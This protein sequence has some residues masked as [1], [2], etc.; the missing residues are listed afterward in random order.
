[1]K[2]IAELAQKELVK[3][4]LWNLIYPKNERN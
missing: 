2:E 1:M 4:N 3:N